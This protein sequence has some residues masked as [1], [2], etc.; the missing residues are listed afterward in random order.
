MKNRFCNDDERVKHNIETFERRISIGN[1][2]DLEKNFFW[3]FA[4]IHM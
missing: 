3:H 1:I 2:V 4:I